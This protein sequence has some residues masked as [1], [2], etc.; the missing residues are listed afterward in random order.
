MTDAELLG[1]VQAEISL[2]DNGA[3]WL[4]TILTGYLVIAYAIGKNLSLFQV[5]FVNVVFILLVLARVDA[6]YTS[7]GVVRSLMELLHEQSPEIA[8]RLG[9]E[10]IHSITVIWVRPIAMTIVVVGA[11]AFMWSVRHPKPE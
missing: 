4:I 11:Y 8:L 5:S 7:Q 2:L 1:L 9:Y 10:R 6:N 3:E